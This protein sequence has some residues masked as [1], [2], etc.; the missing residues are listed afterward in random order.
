MLPKTHIEGFYDDN[1]QREWDRL[2][3][4]RM[5]LAVTLMA[6]DEYLPPSAD[7][8]DIGGGPG[9]YAIE[10]TRRGHT[11]TLLDLAQANLDLAAQKAVEAEVKLHG[12]VHGNALDLSAFADGTFDV[13]LLMGPLYHLISLEDRKRCIQEAKRVLKP[14]GVLFAA[15]INRYGVFVDAAAKYPQDVFDRRELW[16]GIW[17]DGV[18]PPPHDSFT[19]AYF[20]MPGEIVPFIEAKGFTTLNLLGLEG[21]VSGHEDSVNA[22]TGDAWT[23]WV[24]LNYAYA[25]DSALHAASQHLLYVGRKP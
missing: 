7:V 8:L 24:K 19:D 12:A 14:G 10:L 21:I 4:H 5:E 15:F 18:N 25:Q 11:V 22:L 1:A 9:R 16:E 20:A 17:R 2:D 6:L 3:R 23:Y 13:A